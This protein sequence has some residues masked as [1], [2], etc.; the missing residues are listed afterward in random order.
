MAGRQLKEI[1]RAFRTRD[2]LAF[3]R[4]AMEIIEEE[5]AKHHNALARDLQKLL[6]AGGGQVDGGSSIVVPAPPKDREGEWDLGE[7][8][9][10]QR[11][12]ED[13]ILHKLVLSNLESIVEEVRKWPVLDA[14]G[15]PRRQRLLLQ[16]PPGCGKTT[17]A[18]A[19]AAELGR[20]LL[21]VRLDAVVSSYLGETASNLRR[22]LEYA[23]QAPFVVLFDEF[24]AL[25]RS[26]DDGSEHGEMKRVVTAFLQM[27]D[28]YRGPSL[29]LAA[30]NH[31]SLLDEALWRRFDE[32]LTFGLPTVHQLRQVLR[33]RLKGVPHRNIEIDLHASAL[34][35]LPHAAAE[36]LIIDARRNALLRN[37]PIV[38]TQDVKRALTGVTSR[39]W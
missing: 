37:S 5:Q 15:L 6:A 29:L 38:E 16:G 22:I 10:P 36:K 19:L 18:E 14:A 30:T 25:G 28:R 34:K 7:V 9:E 20:P 13:L 8:R 39:P 2:E 23:D 33:L 21:V 12:L 32:V 27:T 26:R 4:A 11:L 24:D 17:A 35:G 3:R 31:P 1:F